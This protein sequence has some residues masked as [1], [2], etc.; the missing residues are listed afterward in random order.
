MRTRRATTER[1]AAIC[2]A[3]T[4][5]GKREAFP[6]VLTRQWMLRQPMRY[7]ENPH[8][9]A[10]FY[11]DLD[12]GPG[13]LAGYE[14]LQGKD[15]SYNNVAD[16]D[17]AWE[18]VRGL[19][20]PACVIVKHANPCGVATARTRSRLTGGRSRPIQRRPSE[21]SSRSTAR[22]RVPVRMPCPSSLPRSSSPRT[23]MRARAT[24]WPPRPT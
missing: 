19:Q 13:L 22:S 6:H 17:A 16:A 8:Q 15:L 20:T 12:P 10:A 2:P 4:P 9:Q 3:S 18:C 21:A 14:Q 7:G 1:S 23:S 5:T 24:R 11:R